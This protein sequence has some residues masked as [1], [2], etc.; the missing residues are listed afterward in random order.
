MLPPILP[1]EL[2]LLPQVRAYSGISWGGFSFVFPVSFV[3]E[4]PKMYSS[5]AQQ[6]HD[7]TGSMVLTL[8]NAL[9]VNLFLQNA[10]A[11]QA[12]LYPHIYWNG[13][14]GELEQVLRLEV[15]DRLSE[16]CIP[17]AQARPQRQAQL[18]F[19][20]LPSRPKSCTDWSFF[21]KKWFYL[22]LHNL[23]LILPPPSSSSHVFFPLSNQKPPFLWLLLI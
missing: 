8:W 22:K 2:W 5:N 23:P 16:K 15:Q 7:E 21:K 1:P 3:T 20:L 6:S 11:L 13:H 14:N 19:A 12:M 9:C 18:A 10:C 17:G 4:F